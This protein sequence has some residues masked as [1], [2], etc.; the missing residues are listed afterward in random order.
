MDMGERDKAEALL[1][2]A[3]ESAERASRAKSDFLA[4]M[5][6]EIRTPLNG[7][8]GMADLLLRTRLSPDQA[9]MAASI[10]TSGDS[11]LLVLHGVLDISK[12]EAGKL[13]IEHIPFHLRDMLF[14]S[15]K[16]L[17]PI[18]FKK[19]LELILHISPS[20]PDKVVGDP[21]RVRQLILNLASNALKFTERGEVLITVK[22]VAQTGNSARLR[23]AVSDTGIGIP[24]GKK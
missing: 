21:V 23:F 3:K 1:R 12:I 19:G 7:V 20:V 9:S 13:G 16:G 24:D 4:N 8:I 6:H 15:V 11:L 2:E 14:D 17:S 18:A 22:S 5:S 10:K